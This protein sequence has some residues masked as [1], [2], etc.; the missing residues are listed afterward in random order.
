MSQQSRDL[1]DQ[2]ESAVIGFDGPPLEA[3]AVLAAIHA[4]ALWAW[5]EISGMSAVDVLAVQERV[6]KAEIDRIAAHGVVVVTH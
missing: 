5:C 4:K 6:V 3:I 1:A 2:I